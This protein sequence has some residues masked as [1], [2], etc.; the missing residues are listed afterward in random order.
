MDVEVIRSLDQVTPGWLTRVLKR[1][2]ALK[3]GA[4]SGFKIADPQ[5]R[6]L[7]TTARLKLRYR[8][9]SSGELPEQL[10]LK[11]VNTVFDDDE[12][13]LISEVDYYSR[14]YSGIEGAPLVRC[15]DSALSED[16]Q[17]YHILLDDLSQT[18]VRAFQKPP[19]LE[20]GLAFAEGLAALHAHWWGGNQLEQRGKPVPGAE[21][22]ERFVAIARLGVEYIL[23]CCAGELAPH[24]PQAIREIYN[25]H[26]QLLVERTRDANG[27]TLIH[28]DV[29]PG[30]VLV[31]VEGD[32]PVYL[33]DRA[34]FEW[35]LTTWLGVYDL[36]YAMV[37]YWEVKTRRELEGP[38]LR[39]YHAGLAERGIDNYSWEKLYED[40]RLMAVMS[41][42]VATEWCRG[43][44]KQ[45][46]D[47]WMPMLQRAMT[48]YDDLEC[49]KLWKDR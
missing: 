21:A 28:G 47:A 49:S 11:M 44:G 19:T 30:N 31:P 45:Y 46:K 20:H 3:V 18:H 10:F 8:T 25:H 33:V 36:S 26:P 39:R 6:E 2:G 9:G 42:Y 17:S 38:V 16:L 27:F 5:A 24:W 22:I 23:D 4:V 32:R 34:P 43:S 13:L 15:Y 37:T 12:P 14:D 7:S 40:Y 41:V 1:D 48:A 35:S 29:N